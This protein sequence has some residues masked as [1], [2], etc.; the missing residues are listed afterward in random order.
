LE[1]ETVSLRFAAGRRSRCRLPPNGAPPTV[2]EAAAGIASEFASPLLKTRVFPRESEGS[3]DPAGVTF[4]FRTMS[5]GCGAELSVHRQHPRSCRGRS[6]LRLGAPHQL[7]HAGQQLDFL[8]RRAV[9]RYHYHDQLHGGEQHRGVRECGLFSAGRD[10][11]PARGGWT[12]GPRIC[13]RQSK[14]GLAAPMRHPLLRILAALL[15][16]VW[17]P[18]CCCQA[19]AW[20]GRS[21]SDRG[22]ARAWGDESCG[23]CT[24]EAPS[25]DEPDCRFPEDGTRPGCPACP[26]CQGSVGASGLIP[27]SKAQQY[28][29]GIEAI[30][31]PA[32]RSSATSL[33]WD[34]KL[35]ILTPG[36]SSAH[37]RANR[38]ALRWHC[39]LNV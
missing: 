27:S 36:H 12:E 25:D 23:C 35:S 5:Q 4:S 9:R 11:R 6:S 30:P 16:G 38:A 3:S 19:S 22:H 14:L 37:I 32:H 39:A 13:S 15:I 26:A 10:L 7:P 29:M 24:D 21:C 31:M 1:P 28:H 33:P 18:L 2:R 34:D 17:S 20:M 8:Y